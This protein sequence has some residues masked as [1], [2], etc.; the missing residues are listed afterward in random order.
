MSG[1]ARVI[2]VGLVLVSSMAGCSKSPTQPSVSLTGPLPQQ[3]S[4]GSQ[5]AFANQPVTLTVQNATVTNGGAVTYTFEVATDG[6]FA[7][8]VQ[9]KDGVAEGSGQTSVKLDA[10]AGSKDYFW[11]AR[12]NS[13]GT[14]GPFGST[15]TFTLGAPVVIN[16]PVPI[17]PL[18]GT[19]V[20]VR[21]AFRVT[22]VAHPANA[23]AINYKF[24]VATDIA[25]TSIVATATQPE[26]INETGFIPTSDL[27]INTPLFWR[28]VAIDTASSVSSAASPVQSITA[29]APSQAELVA[30]QLGQPLWPANQPP[31]A[32]GHA[33]MGDNWQVQTL[34][35][36]PT[37]TFFLSP[38]LEMLRLF[39]LL[40][41]GF[42]PDGAI[43]WMNTNG[44]PTAAFWYPPPEKAV[45]GLEFVYLAAR[46]KIVVNGTWELV[47]KVE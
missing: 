27:P 23:G 11:H 28:A 14:P 4:T 1:R 15:S 25:F 41:R 20:T 34:H 22:N 37:N 2:L 38:T 42:D 21:P 5:V 36:V 31:G 7:N 47:L 17:A 46:D 39:D 29:R 3:P 33:T 24:D 40:D 43:N 10:L 13:S 26:G 18:S 19:T 45:I 30:A 8:K 16:A 12:A 9:T 6:G 44:Y 32:L 35:H